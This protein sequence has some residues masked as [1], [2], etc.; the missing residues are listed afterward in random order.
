LWEKQYECLA[1]RWSS[2]GGVDIALGELMICEFES[3]GSQLQF[4][5]SHTIGD[6]GRSMK[7]FPFLRAQIMTKTINLRAKAIPPPEQALRDLIRSTWLS[8]SG[9]MSSTIP[10]RPDK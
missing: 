9:G 10:I 8:S 1:T 7:V 5:T 3:I 2:A 4:P 6:L